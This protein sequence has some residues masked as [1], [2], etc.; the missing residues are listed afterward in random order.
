M[1]KGVTLLVRDN[2]ELL[3]RILSAFA[4][5]VQRCKDWFYE[6]EV[7]GQRFFAVDNG[8]E[9]YTLMLPEEY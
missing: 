5:E 6:L 3:R 2:Q 7:D 9:G 8:E 4:E 1:T